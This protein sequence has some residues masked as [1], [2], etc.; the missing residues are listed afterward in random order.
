MDLEVLLTA[1][2]NFEK[3]LIAL[4]SAPE[5]QE[6]EGKADEEAIQTV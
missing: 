1:Q 6:A 2:A 3:E 5:L 4:K